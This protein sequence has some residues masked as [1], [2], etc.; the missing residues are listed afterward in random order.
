MKAV[1]RDSTWAES[2][3]SRKML[4]RLGRLRLGPPEEKVEVAVQAIN[5]VDHLERLAERVLEVSNWQEL[6]STL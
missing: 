4:L 3:K 1:P 2:M 6:L 5:D